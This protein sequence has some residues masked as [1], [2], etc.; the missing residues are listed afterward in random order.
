MENPK[1]SGKLNYSYK[2]WE[3]PGRFYPI[4]PC[5]NCG[6]EMPGGTGFLSKSPCEDENY[7]IL[8]MKPIL[9]QYYFSSPVRDW[10]PS[11]QSSSSCQRDVLPPAYSCRG[12]DTPRP[13]EVTWAPPGHRVPHA[14]PPCP[15]TSLSPRSGCTCF[16]Q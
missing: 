14:Q 13:C 7:S 2:M 11:I 8:K 12:E 3:T 6:P 9:F 5:R 15:I 4:Q 10:K 1:E 16:W